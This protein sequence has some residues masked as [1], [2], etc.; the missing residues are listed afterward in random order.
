MGWQLFSVEGKH[1][2]YLEGRVRT[3][4]SDR[5]KMGVN[6]HPNKSVKDTCD[7]RLWSPLPSYN[8]LP[9]KFVFHAK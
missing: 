3:Q 4:S 1:P 5:H 2:C 7:D 6:D 8:K 9:E